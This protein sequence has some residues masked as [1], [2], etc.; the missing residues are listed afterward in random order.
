MAEAAPTVSPQQAAN[1][2]QDQMVNSTAPVQAPQEAP[3]SVGAPTTPELDVSPSEPSQT[4]PVSSFGSVAPNPLAD[5]QAAILNPDYQYGGMFSYG[6][7]KLKQYG[8]MAENAMHQ[9]LLN[10]T[11]WQGSPFQVMP[12]TKAQIHQKRAEAAALNV[13]E[14]SIPGLEKLPAYLATLPLDPDFIAA[15]VGAKLAMYPVNLAGHIAVKLGGRVTSGIVKKAFGFKP[16][17]LGV[18]GALSSIGWTGVQNLDADALNEKFDDSNYAANAITFMLV[19]GAAGSLIHWGLGAGIADSIATG[20]VAMKKGLTPMVTAIRANRFVKKAFGQVGDEVA[21]GEKA[22]DAPTNDTD[23]NTLDEQNV[24]NKAAHNEARQTMGLGKTAIPKSKMQIKLPKT[25]TEV[26]DDDVQK[27]L[28]IRSNVVHGVEFESPVDAAIFRAT[29]APEITFKNKYLRNIYRVT[30]SDEAAVYQHAGNLKTIVKG[31]PNQ[32]VP[33]VASDLVDH[34]KP[35]IDPNKMKIM[36]QRAETPYSRAIEKNTALMADLEHETNGLN[37]SYFSDQQTPPIAKRWRALQVLHNSLHRANQEYPKLEDNVL[38]K[39]N[40]A[41]PVWAKA[42]QTM[43]S[44]AMQHAVLKAKVGFREAALNDLDTPE[45][46]LSDKDV[47]FLKNEPLD[48]DL[49]LRLQAES[50][51]DPDQGMFSR[52]MQEKLRQL[53]STEGVELKGLAQELATVAERGTDSEKLK[54]WLSDLTSCLL[55]NES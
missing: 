5:T 45:P 12:Y 41:N 2:T 53:Y 10:S 35:F 26:T 4:T 1:L 3:P 15:G 20:S 9:S 50:L 21:T 43:D 37:D 17:S 29:T 34:V 33:T 18:Q 8:A 32:V 46:T 16:F 36:M 14:G 47:S 38:G 30:G 39:L 27:E 11:A 23:W 13:E 42:I 19:G 31:F 54:G 25:L 49:Q 24:A 6:W 40:T 48:S 52:E 7:D 51:D 44:T 22:P 28:G 55:N